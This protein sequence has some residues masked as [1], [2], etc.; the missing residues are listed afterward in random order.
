MKNA[1]SLQQRLFFLIFTKR[2]RQIPCGYIKIAQ[3]KSRFDELKK[4]RRSLYKTNDKTL[5]VYYAEDV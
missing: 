5:Q 3:L 2:L 4:W 1:E